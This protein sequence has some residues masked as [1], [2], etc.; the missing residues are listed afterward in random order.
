MDDMSRQRLHRDT[1]S[2]VPDLRDLG[3]DGCPSHVEILPDG[4][5]V[6][7]IAI[8]RATK[9]HASARARMSLGFLEPAGCA[10]EN[11]SAPSAWMLA[12]TTS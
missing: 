4:R 8:Q 1:A 12:K 5:E 9:G 11:I 10:C 6:G 7:V 2:E 3:S